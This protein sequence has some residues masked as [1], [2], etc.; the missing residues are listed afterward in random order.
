[1]RTQDQITILAVA[2][3]AGLAGANP[4]AGE[5]TDVNHCDNHGFRYAVEELGEGVLFPQNE[6]I[7]TTWNF[8]NLTACP[9]SDDPNV[10]NVLVDMRNLTGL[11]WQD[12]FYVA[13]PE[14]SFSNFDGMAMSYAAPGV[15]T[16]AFR[17]DPFGMNKNLVSETMTADNIFEP[18]EAWQFIIQDYSNAAG[19]PPSF[20]SL[21]FSG[22]SSGDPIS[23][24]S[25]V[26]FPVPTPGSLALLGLGGLATLRRR[27]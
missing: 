10:P 9:M 19:L 22:A 6:L 18:G 12:L 26:Q 25:I 27:R 11:Y 7:Q 21:D 14:T 15:I 23:S 1:M 13:D 20:G 5:Y 2:L 17:I 16:P 24:G 4:V 3:L 8:T